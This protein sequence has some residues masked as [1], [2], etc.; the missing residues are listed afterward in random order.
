[1]ILAMCVCAAHADSWAAPAFSSDH[2]NM[3]QLDA[4][5]NAWML[6]SV[7]QGHLESYTDLPLVWNGDFWIGRDGWNW[8]GNPRYAV[9][10]NGSRDLI[11]AHN[12]FCVGMSFAPAVAG[13]YAW[14]GTA[15]FIG[16]PGHVCTAV[17]GKWSAANVWTEVSR[18]D[19]TMPDDWVYTFDLSANAAL[20]N[21]SVGAGERLAISLI[22]TNAEYHA[23]RLNQNRSDLVRIESVPEPASLVALA[24][25]MFGLAGLVLRRRH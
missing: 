1:M 21:V 13:N 19:I 12:N 15:F 2:V 23:F 25:G 11:F 24:S 8:A 5:G 3:P 18:Y 16:T 10:G 14:K 20:Q 6:Y 17:F 4:G 9:D 7:Q 22:G